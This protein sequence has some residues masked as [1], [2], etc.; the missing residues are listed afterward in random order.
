MEHD[1]HSRPAV[2]LDESQQTARVIRVAVAQNNGVQLVAL[3]FEH[4]HIVQHAVDGHAGIEQKGIFVAAF[5]GRH[6][7][8]HA[9]LGAQLRSRVGRRCSRLCALGDRRVAHQHVDGIIHHAQVF[10]RDRRLSAAPTAMSN[11]LLHFVKK[12]FLQHPVDNLFDGL[13]FLAEK[14]VLAERIAGSRL[15]RRTAIHA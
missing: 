15:R 6:E 8:G 11:L 2:A 5:V 10:P 7:H 12:R 13:R 1:R 4:I 9:V 14:A 3:D